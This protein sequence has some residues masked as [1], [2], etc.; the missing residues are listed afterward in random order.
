MRILFVSSPFPNR[1]KEYLVL[2]SLEVCILSSLLK[3]KG[4]T[5]GLVDMKI[6]RV[7]GAVL[8]Q[9]TLDFAPDVIC[10]E[11]EPKSHCCSKKI[12]SLLRE[13]FPDVKILIRGE[14]PSFIP[15]TILE[16]NPGLD[17]IL[18][19]T[20]DYSLLKIIDANFEPTA[21]IQIPN[22]AFRKPDRQIVVTETRP[23]D[24]AL[25]S[26][27]MPDRRLYD[28]KKYLKRDIET[29]VKSSRGCPGNCLFCI[30]TRFEKFLLFSVQR[31]CDEIEELL[32][33]GFRSFFFADDTFAFSDKRL[34][35]F[36]QEVKKRDLKFRW[37]S[38]IRIKDINDYKLSRMKEI[39]AYRVFVGIETI[40][41][42]TQQTINKN[43]HEELIREKL[44][45]IKKYGLE[46]HA[47]FILGNPG[48]T[49]DDLEATIRFV[50][51]VA[52]TLVTF[53][54]IRV[55]PGL[56]LY[57]DPEKYGIVMDDP[58]WYESDE[59]SYKVVMGTK[60]L[61]PAVLEKW[62]RRCLWEFINGK[63]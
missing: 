40:N 1:V 30:K 57:T 63:Q 15:D 2:P 32:D 16:R 41:S 22:I 25:D 20:D 47:S 42:K 9:R 12:I 27:P 49:E 43:L 50:R 35:E 8:L 23:I 62:S 14:L 44:Q 34:D 55:Y 11:D 38:N 21:L 46:F 26:L 7:E 24:Y 60:Q 13:Q 6:E 10:I 59:W 17:A 3:E 37:T 56:D 54:L 39:G 4:H 29:I 31:F 5:I 18:R 45:L 19:F 52:P 28:I 48:D 61:P 36:Y 51:E 53:N 58:Y 33:I